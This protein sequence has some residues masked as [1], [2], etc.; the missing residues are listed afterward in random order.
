MMVYHGITSEENFAFNWISV[1]FQKI[2]KKM[3]IARL[4]RGQVI[5]DPAI[6]ILKIK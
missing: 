6:N 3:R 1:I 2:S 4:D 5:K